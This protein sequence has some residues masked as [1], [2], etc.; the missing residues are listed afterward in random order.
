MYAYVIMAFDLS[1]ISSLFTSEISKV[2]KRTV[3]GL[4]IG[5]SAIKIVQLNDTKG[6]PTLE[7]Y[8]EL[9]LG[10]YENVEIGRTTHLPTGKQVEAFVDI[11][12]EASATATNIAC[13]ISYNSSFSTIISVA[14]T[15]TEKI[16]TMIPVEAKKY[17]PVPLN[18]VTLDW[19]PVSAKSESKTTK[20][21]L[22][23]IHNDALKNTKQL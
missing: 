12:R 2:Q 4:D 9:Q 7:T 16:G 1:K 21:L 23:A 3:V 14:T 6:V 11:M 22:A 18:E 20:V 13:A 17:V 15:D 5:S 10:P 8:G 19:F